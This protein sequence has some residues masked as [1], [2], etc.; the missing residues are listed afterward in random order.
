MEPWRTS[1][2]AE[3]CRGAKGVEVARDRSISDRVIE[4]RSFGN[5][6]LIRRGMPMPLCRA[7]RDKRMSGLTT[8]GQ[9]SSIAFGSLSKGSPYLT[10]WLK[11][12]ALS[13]R[14]TQYLNP[15]LISEPI[16]RDLLMDM[17]S[18]AVIVEHNDATSGDSIPEVLSSSDLGC[19][20]VHIN[21]K[22]AYMV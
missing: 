16:E 21:R 13:G 22:I 9:R 8:D 19:R 3:R 5:A 2:I 4:Q 10:L 6:R 15:A 14:Q 20:T 12:Q 11:Y 18:P 1:R 7:A 17:L